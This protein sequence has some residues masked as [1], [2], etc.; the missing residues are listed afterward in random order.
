MWKK[1]LI[2]VILLIL[3]IIGIELFYIARNLSKEDDEIQDD[4]TFNSLNE[5]VNELDET[6]VEAE[7]VKETSKTLNNENI[8]YI[9]KSEDG[10]INVYY[11]DENEEKI[12][13]KQTEISIK[14]LSQED[15]DSLEDG[16]DVYGIQSLNKLLEDFE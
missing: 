2:S 13:Y 10:F 3:V 1:I 11:I 12:L 6:N 4:N 5:I 16:I 14:Y 15:V 8:H 9:L 7:E